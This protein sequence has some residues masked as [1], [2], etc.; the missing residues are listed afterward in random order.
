MTDQVSG[1][2]A[3]TAQMSVEQL[4][5]ARVREW[6]GERRGGFV[7]LT[8]PREPGR[9]WRMRVLPKF[10]GVKG[11]MGELASAARGHSNVRVERS[12]LHRWAD[13]VE[14]VLAGSGGGAEGATK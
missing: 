14:Q 3:S 12:E 9:G 13:G 7:M 6:A 1:A 5:I 10:R 8:I 11:V 4:A 2:D